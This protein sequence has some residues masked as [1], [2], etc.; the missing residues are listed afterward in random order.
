VVAV[1]NKIDRVPKPE[2]LPLL[3]TIAG[4]G[5]LTEV[6]PISALKGDGI[7]LLE[8][9]LASHLPESPPFYPPDQLSDQPE[10]FFAA[11]LVREQIFRRYK[12]EV[13][14]STAVEITTFEE[15]PERKKVHIRAQVVVERESQKGILI[16]KGGLALK[17]VGQDARVDIEALLGRPVYLELFVQV[18]REW[19]RDEKYLEEQGL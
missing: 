12:E 11:E 6:V 7:E 8:S 15:E 16:G 3:S 5:T 1:L 14:Y 18:R 2:L 9:L 17:Q 10:K 13:P 4:V 19:R